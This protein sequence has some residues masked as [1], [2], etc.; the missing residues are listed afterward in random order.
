MRKIFF[1]LFALI[2]VFHSYAQ[3]N[4]ILI[5][6]DDLGSDYC[7]FY[8]DHEDTAALPNISTLLNRGVRF[9]NAMSNPWCSPTR[10]GI[11]TGR[12]SFRTGVG[13]VVGDGGSL[14]TGEITIPRLLKIYNPDI[15]TA[16]IGKWHLQLNKQYNWS[17][18]NIMGYDYYAGSFAGLPNYYDWTKITNG[19]SSSV[20]NYATTEQT[21]DA[22]SWIKTQTDKPFFLWLAFNAPHAPRHLPPPGFIPILP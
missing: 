20:T 17:Y 9:Q 15:G 1:L 3:H 12:Y 19:V 2:F 8:E 14:D 18:P 5:I 16:Q 11:F 6:A 22:F 13:A 21:D 7:G 10:S 4:V